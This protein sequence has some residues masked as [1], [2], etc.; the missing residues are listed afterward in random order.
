MKIKVMV[1]VCLM[2][3]GLQTSYSADKSVNPQVVMVTNIGD[4]TIE[5]NAEKAPKSVK[6]FLAYAEKSFYNGLIFH[7]V[8]KGFMNQTGSF[9][10]KFQQRPANP[11]IKNEANNGLLNLK[12]TIA[13]ARTSNPHS[14]SS[15]FFINMNDNKFLDFQSEDAKG[16]GYAVFGKVVAGMEIMEKLNNMPT[17][18]SGIYNDVPKDMIV[19]KSIKIKEI[20]T[21]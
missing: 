21:P 3:L 11:P 10:A 13:M 20:K 7:R 18:P 15:Q 2:V 12:G 8:I 6:N 5:L 14:A 4:V 17:G 1:V 19:I 9:D 16:W